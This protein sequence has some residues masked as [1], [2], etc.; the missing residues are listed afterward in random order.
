[1]ATSLADLATDDNAEYGADN[2]ED[3][4]VLDSTNAVDN[5]G[6]DDESKE[7]DAEGDDA[8]GDDAE[9]DDAEVSDGLLFPK[10]ES[11]CSIYTLS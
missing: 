8:E 11:I 3:D 1:L 9:G 6:K 5:D 4:G 2:I 7:E 10:N